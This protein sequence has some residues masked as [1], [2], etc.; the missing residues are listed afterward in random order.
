M[1]QMPIIRDNG[2]VTLSLIFQ[3]NNAHL[4]CVG[5]AVRDCFLGQYN[6]NADI[7]LSI[8]LTPLQVTE[9]LV[10][11]NIPYFEIGIEFGTVTAHY[12]GKNYEITSFRKDIQ[13]DGRHAVVTYGTDMASDAQRRD[14]TMNALYCDAQGVIYDP[15]GCGISDLKAHKIRFIGCADL[16]IKEDYLRILRYFRFLARFGMDTYEADIFHDSPHYH[17]GLRALSEHRIRNELNKLILYPYAVDVLNEIIHLG[18]DEILFKDMVLDIAMFDRYRNQSQKH[19]YIVS[20][21]FFKTNDVNIKKNT[22]LIKQEKRK[23]R[24]FKALYYQLKHYTFMQDWLQISMLY[25]AYDIELWHELLSIIA[26]E[27]TQLSQKIK[28]IKSFVFPKFTLTGRDLII[29][30]Y[31]EGKIISKTLKIKK[32]HQLEAFLNIHFSIENC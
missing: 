29:Q 31:K 18:Y 6:A 28:K 27:Y 19:K 21:L 12:Q 4:Y 14:F 20:S 30:G 15:L 8:S 13:T 5:G 2:F 25:D 16:R 11:E 24:S 23:V 7:D 3:K 10:S 32:Q 22:L 17:D 1:Q 26:L 9:I